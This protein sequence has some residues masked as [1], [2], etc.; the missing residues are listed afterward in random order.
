MGKEGKK[1]L[2]HSLLLVTTKHRITVKRIAR[3]TGGLPSEGQEA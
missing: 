2:S 3:Y 1:K